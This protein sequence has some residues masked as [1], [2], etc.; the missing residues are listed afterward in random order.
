MDKI[1]LRVIALAN[2]SSQP[3]SFVVV[4]K[5]MEGLRRLPVVIGGFEAQS[6]AI[7][8]EGITP[9][10]PLTHDLFRN[11][12]DALDVKLQEVVISDLREGIFYGTL[13]CEQQNGEKLEMDART[14]D[15]IAL[16]VRFGCPIFTYPFI[17]DQAGMVWEDE[18]EGA[19]APSPKAD[20]PLNK[21]SKAQ[22][23]QALDEALQEENYERA[24][25][26]RDEIKQRESDAN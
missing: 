11:T 16:A 18:E 22:L 24:A 1:E 3:S 8:V 9:A 25:K 13:V 5:E 15:A 19:P 6:I 7:A 4:L 17:M 23:D 26:I 10:R 21:L 20:V 14:S 2:S 12:M